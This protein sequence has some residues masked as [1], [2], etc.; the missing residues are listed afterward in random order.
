MLANDN[1]LD[2]Q[3]FDVDKVLTAFAAHLSYNLARLQHRYEG[4]MCL[5]ILAVISCMVS[6]IKLRSSCIAYPIY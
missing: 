2:L 1:S 5:Q 3:F 4:V 6:D